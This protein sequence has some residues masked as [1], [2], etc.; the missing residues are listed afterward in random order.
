MGLYKVVYIKIAKQHVP[1]YT[2]RKFLNMV[3]YHVIE[4]EGA[5]YKPK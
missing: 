2:L 1:T 3:F 5:G 4:Y